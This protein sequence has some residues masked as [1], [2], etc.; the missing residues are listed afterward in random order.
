LLAPLYNYE[1]LYAGEH[2]SDLGIKSQV[3]GRKQRDDYL[4]KN[5]LPR[6]HYLEFIVIYLLYHV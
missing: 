1:H 2:L 5:Q 6:Y 4:T 3:V